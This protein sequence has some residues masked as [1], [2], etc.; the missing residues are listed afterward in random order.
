MHAT[1]LADPDQINTVEVGQVTISA[2]RTTDGGT[3]IHLWRGP[4]RHNALTLSYRNPKLGEHVRNVIAQMAA[5]GAT[6]AQI[7]ATLGADAEYALD[8]VRRILDDALAVATGDD[9]TVSGMLVAALQEAKA[10]TESAAVR[11]AAGALA[12]DISTHLRDTY[13]RCGADEPDDAVD[14]LTQVT[15][16]RHTAVDGAVRASNALTGLR[17]THAATATN[18]PALRP[19]TNRRLTPA[20]LD[21]LAAAADNDGTVRLD[22]EDDRRRARA[23]ARRGNYLTLVHTTHGVP[24]SLYRAEITGL[25]RR[26]LT[27]AAA[28]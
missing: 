4:S 27:E 16:D 22:R 18:L 14:Y 6:A 13:G 12:A 21:L 26:A 10:D 11:A 2:Q 5:T 20:M 23:I 25:G 24:E 8:Q 28:R 1:K 15:A 17:D 7:A 19:G 9:S 3:T